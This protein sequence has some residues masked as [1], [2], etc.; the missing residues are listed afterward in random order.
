MAWVPIGASAVGSI[1]GN[2]GSASSSGTTTRTRQFDQ[3]AIDKAIYDIMASDQGLAALATAE[4]A[5]GGYKSSG[6]TLLLTDQLINSWGFQ[7]I[8]MLTDNS[9][10]TFENI[11]KNKQLIL[12][13]KQ[14]NSLF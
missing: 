10:F 11:N 12:R 3:K 8:T 13:I 4:N 7:N 14:Q 1:L 2:T 5:S 9:N 6:K